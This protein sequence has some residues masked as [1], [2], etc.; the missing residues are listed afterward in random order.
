MA[1]THALGEARGEA[2]TG[3]PVATPLWLVKSPSRVQE[4]PRAGQ[5]KRVCPAAC[6]TMLVSSQ[7]GKWPGCSS[8]PS[9]KRACSLADWC[10]CR[11]QGLQCLC[12]PSVQQ[13]SSPCIMQL[14]CMLSKA[15]WLAG[16]LPA[17]RLQA[18]STAGGGAFSSGGHHCPHR[19]DLQP[20][21]YSVY[22]AGT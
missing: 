6:R 5:S 4:S 8:S 22:L 21:T 9:S 17:H 3:E 19:H 1:H 14:N 16:H 18:A 2:A 12:M 10:P 15:A 20:G 7:N 11:Q 13:P